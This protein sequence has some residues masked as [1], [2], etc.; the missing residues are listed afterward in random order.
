MPVILKNKPGLWLWFALAMLLSACGQSEPATA[1]ANGS[2]AA[3]EQAAPKVVDQPAQDARATAPSAK[4]AG[5]SI[6]TAATQGC[7]APDAS[8]CAV[9][10]R[11]TPAG[12][13]RYSWSGS[14]DATTQPWYNVVTRVESCPADGPVCARCSQRDEASLKALQAQHRSVDC[15]SMPPQVDACM[16]PGS[17]ACYCS[18]QARLQQACPS[19]DGAA[20]ARIPEQPQGQPQTQTKTQP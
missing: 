10:Y 5:Y 6:A 8:G 16:Q 17:D 19:A 20:Q 2:Q 11:S 4:A 1:T 7:R 12:C 18:R 13:S 9:C 3:V 15:S 14:E